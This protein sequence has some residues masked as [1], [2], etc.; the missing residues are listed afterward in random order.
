M[1]DGE[2]QQLVDKWVAEGGGEEGRRFK[3]LTHSCL[4]ALLHQVLLREL[5]LLRCCQPTSREQGLEAWRQLWPAAVRVV[6]PC[7]ALVQARPRQAGTHTH[8]QRA[9]PAPAPV[10]IPAPGPNPA[11]PYV[12]LSPAP[13]SL[14]RASAASQSPPC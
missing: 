6:P 9:Y 3:A 12:P 4:R 7:P 10:P 14:P 1:R 2:G 8:L 13:C 11:A 5:L